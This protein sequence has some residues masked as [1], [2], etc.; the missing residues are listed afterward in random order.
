MNCCRSQPDSSRGDIYDG[1]TYTGP[2]TPS[3]TGTRAAV[4][5]EH[6]GLGLKVDGHQ[7]DPAGSFAYEMEPDSATLTRRYGELQRRLSLVAQRCG[8]SAG[9]YTQATDVE[10]AVNGFFTYDRQVKKMDFAAVWVANVA[11]VKGAT[12]G[13]VPGPVVPPGTPGLDGVAA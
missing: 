4:D 6:G 9:F 1:H 11:L 5:G 3:R 10:K 8:V 12:G 7:Y 13:P 2:G